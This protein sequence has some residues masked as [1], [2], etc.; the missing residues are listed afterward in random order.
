MFVVFTDLDGTLLDHKTYSYEKAERGI[1][2][3]R[4]KK[5]PLVLVSSK[6][7]DEMKEI[8]CSLSLDSP[9]IFENGAGIAKVDKDCAKGYSIK[10]IGKNS[11]LL[12]EKIELIQD[13]LGE[14]I[15]VLVDMSIKQIVKITGL[16]EEAAKQASL[17]KA[18]MPFLLSSNKV[19]NVK[20]LK[21]INEKLKE[22]SLQVTKGGRFYHF[23]SIEATKGN[24]LKKVV[25]QYE[26]KIF[27]KK[28][29]SIAIGDSEN[30]IAMLE[31]VNFP[32]LV[33]K[34]D[35]SFIETGIQDITITK[36]IGPRGFSEIVEKYI[37]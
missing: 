34:F 17:R 32:Y 33:R 24:A 1:G 37:K 25:A 12:Y 26:K 6:T 20:D 30:D 11:D 36:N 2:I 14:K 21:I 29:E 23:S 15:T 28:I 13:V 27:P 31:V 8:H 3:L 18:S 19:Y 16:S 5:I 22:E 4:Q 35:N 7:F 9:F 10:L